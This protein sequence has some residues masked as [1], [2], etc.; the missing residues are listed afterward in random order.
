MDLV[1]TLIFLTILLL[2][3]AFLYTSFAINRLVLRPE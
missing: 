2:I 1:V 3:N